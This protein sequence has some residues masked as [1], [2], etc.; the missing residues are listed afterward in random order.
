MPVVERQPAIEH[1]PLRASGLVIGSAGLVTLATGIYFGHRAQALGDEVTGACHT[2]CDW[3]TWKSK[4]DAGRSDAKLATAL[5]VVGAVGL[6]GGAVVY[7]LGMREDVAIVPTSNG[8][9]I[10]A[11]SGSW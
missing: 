7:Y 5:D 1:P 8:G 9:A 2:S 4:D 10:A 3:A 6:V 11:W